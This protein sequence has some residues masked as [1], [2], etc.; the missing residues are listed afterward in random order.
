MSKEEILETHAELFKNLEEY[1]LVKNA[2]NYEVEFSIIHKTDMTV[3]LI[4]KDINEVI[5]VMIELGVQIAGNEEEITPPDFKAYTVIWS[6][7]KQDWEKVLQE[8]F[9]RIL[10]EKNKNRK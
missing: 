3:V 7:E 6:E 5:D 2:D 8:D 1:A 4:E 10:E 9:I